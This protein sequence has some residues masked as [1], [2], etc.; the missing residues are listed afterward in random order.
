MSH[1]L[2]TRFPRRSILRGWALA[3]A[4][5]LGASWFAGRSNGA[6]LRQDRGT[7]PA[8]EQAKVLERYREGMKLEE[9]R[10]EFQRSAGRWAFRSETTGARFLV[11][12]NLSLQRVAE[13]VTESPEA[14]AWT[15]SG[16]ITEFRGGRFLLLSRAV[17]R[18]GDG[19][20][21]L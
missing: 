18:A 10:G 21:A 6:G 20:E 17:Q 4:G 9:E 13:Q 11:L 3:T 16:L 7:A 12:E 1:Q 8:S 19:E 5:A 2:L 15:V 14:T